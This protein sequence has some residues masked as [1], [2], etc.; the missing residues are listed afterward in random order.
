MVKL[1]RAIP[2]NISFTNK[3]SIHSCI[4][5]KPISDSQVLF[6][7]L[8]DLSNYKLFSFH[9]RHPTPWD[10]ELYLNILEGI[11]HTTRY[12][13]QR[14]SPIIVKHLY[15]LYSLF[16]GKFMPLANFRTALICVFSFM[17][18]FRLSEIIELLI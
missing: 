3:R 14:K 5:I 4:F 11:K 6:N 7:H 17:G 13:V 8:F 12:T 9:S 15:K 16:G 10:S 18:F 1:D 2:R